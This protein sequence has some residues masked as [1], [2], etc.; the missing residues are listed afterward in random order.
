M[1][2][3]TV[4]SYTTTTT[5]TSDSAT[6]D[7]NR[8]SIDSDEFLLLMVQQLQYQD[9]TDPADTGEYLSQLA[10]Y[11]STETLTEISDQ[12][13]SLTD[14]VSSF[15]NTQGLGYLNQTVEAVGN[16][17]SLQDGEANWSYTLDSDAE[18]VTVS[19]YDAD[20]NLVYSEDGETSEGS[21]SFTWDGVTSDGEQLEDGGQ[22][23]IVVDA[24]DSDG[25]EVSGST[26]VIAEVTAVD[27]SGDDVVLGI[28]DA[29]VLLEN[30]LAVASTG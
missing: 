11:S 16:T 19:I 25:N 12:L 30:V 2:I 1:S 4:N 10:S 7:A 29:A 21:H 24:T 14:S 20:G 22:Y 26:T 15:M 9:P 3:S 6:E 17:T 13:S 27:S 5:T 8:T 18:S 28:G 23:T